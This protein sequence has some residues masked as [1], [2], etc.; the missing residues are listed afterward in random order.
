MLDAAYTRPTYQALHNHRGENEARCSD[1]TLARKR[2]EGIQRCVI[3]LTLFHTGMRVGALQKVRILELRLDDPSPHIAIPAGNAKNRK[4][5]RSQLN[6][7]MIGI[8]K[9]WLVEKLAEARAKDRREGRAERAALAPTD[10]LFDMPKQLIK[11][12]DRDLAYAGLTKVDELGRKLCVHSFRY[13][14]ATNLLCAGVPLR[15]VQDMMH[16]STPLLTANIYTDVSMLP[17]K[18]ASETLPSFAAPWKG[19]APIEQLSGDLQQLQLTFEGDGDD[20]DDGP[21]GGRPKRKKEAS[22]LPLS[23]PGRL[24]FLVKTW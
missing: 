1:E 23:L 24:S 21:G 9:P 2:Y 5:N 15:V 12:L 6:T 17:T 4:R 7:F 11:L 10:L 3:Y 8:L 18:E 22:R 16:H 19:L 20:D 13:S 14:Y